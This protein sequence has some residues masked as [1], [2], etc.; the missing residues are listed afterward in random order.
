MKGRD[1]FQRNCGKR[2]K[3]INTGSIHHDICS[4]QSAMQTTLG[5]PVVTQHSVH[6]DMTSRIRLHIFRFTSQRDQAIHDTTT[7]KLVKI[8]LQ[9]YVGVLPFTFC[10]SFYC[11]YTYDDVLLPS[12]EVR[13]DDPYTKASTNVDVP[14][15]ICN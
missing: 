9:Q 3:I 4:G 7:L 10:I 13:E 14:E 5:L 15:V 2:R 8:D 11:E 6:G 1:G 12:C